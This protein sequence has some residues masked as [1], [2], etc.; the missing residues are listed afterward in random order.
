MG[1]GTKTKNEEP[2][3]PTASVEVNSSKGNNEEKENGMG[4]YS[5]IAKGISEEYLPYGFINN[6]GEKRADEQKPYVCLF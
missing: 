2:R 1:K 6:V 3:L 5:T 4:K